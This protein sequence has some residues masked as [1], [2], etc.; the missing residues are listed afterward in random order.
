MITSE[1]KRF[2]QTLTTEDI[3]EGV[4]KMAN[5]VLEHL[6]VLRPLSTSQGSRV[7]K[8]VALSQTHWQTLASEINVEIN[9]RANNSNPIIRL[10]KR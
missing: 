4:R 2:V 3:P 10:R 6:D 8:I 5:L 1:Y 9:H 7:K